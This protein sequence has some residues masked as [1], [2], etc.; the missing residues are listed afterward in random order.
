MSLLVRSPATLSDIR[1]PVESELREFD[2]FFKAA[3]RSIVPLDHVQV[4]C[5]GKVA[6]EVGMT[7][8][9]KSSDASGTIPLDGSGWCVLRAFSDKAEYPILDLYPYATTSPVYVSV[10]SAPLHKPEDA[11]FF[12]AWMDRLIGAADTNTSWNTDAEKSAVLAAFREARGKYEA[13][14]H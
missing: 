2:H 4:V 3:M 7:H 11:K 10:T 13:L 12:V 5:N 14:S 6:R 9:R 8:D 1:K